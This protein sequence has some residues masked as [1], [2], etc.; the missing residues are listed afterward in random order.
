MT[1]RIPIT[2]R[3]Q[4]WRKLAEVHAFR[5]RNCGL[6]LTIADLREAGV[7]DKDI[8][9]SMEDEIAA[10]IF[11]RWGLDRSFAYFDGYALIDDLD[12]VTQIDQKMTLREGRQARV[13]AC[14]MFAE[15]AETGDTP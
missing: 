10:E 6:C 4:A 12:D 7:L 9:W 11:A 14:L 2:D 1:R 15:R 5:R 8:S 3:A 13:L